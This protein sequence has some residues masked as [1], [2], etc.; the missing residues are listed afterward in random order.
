MKIVNMFWIFICLTIFSCKDCTEKKTICEKPPMGFNSYDCYRAY[1]DQKTAKKLIDVMAE[2]YLPFGYEYFVIDAGWYIEYQVDPV[3]KLPVQALHTT[4][5]VSNIDENGLPEPSKVYF[6]DG[7]KALADYAH[8]KGLKFGLHLM[9][10]VIRQAIEE[11]CTV[12]G[13]DIPVKDIAD[14]LSICT[15]SKLAYGVDMDKPGAYEYYESMVDKMASWGVDF[16]KYDDIT[17]Y[18]REIK[19]VVE[20]IEKNPEDI[21]LSLS[22]GG[23][24]KME[25][26]PHY[27]ETNMLRITSDIWDNQLS[28]DRTFT[29]MKSFQGR[30]R[31]GFWPDLDMIS[32]GPLEVFDV[33]GTLGTT[34]KGKRISLL[35]KNQSYT[36]ITQRA[37][38]ATPLFIGGDMLTM[39]DFTRQLLTNKDMLACNQNGVTSFLIYEKDS[40]EIY[41]TP[42]RDSPVVKGWLAV[43]NRKNTETLIAFYKS[44]LGFSYNQSV[45]DKFK[46]WKDYNLRDI[47]QSKEYVLKDSIELNIPAN[48]VVFVEYEAL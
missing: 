9:R 23:D 19:A 7:M 33:D 42:E 46:K 41:K 15:W 30:G 14:T 3:T 43:F 8:S 47:W 34:K 4:K 45:L 37:I 32:L 40:I 16:I 12:K 1:L 27:E 17:A 6:P 26:L 2:E 39:D 13:T 44:D 29:G 48:G 28:I 25:Y 21:V 31:P 38:S 11:G 22:P 10:G 18:P 24:V 5:I 35:D 20:A 36:F